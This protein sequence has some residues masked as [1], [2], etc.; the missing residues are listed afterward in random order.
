MKW[1]TIERSLP[2]RLSPDSKGRL[3]MRYGQNAR[4]ENAGVEKSGA[5]SRGGKR[6]SRQAVW[7]TEPILYIERHLSYFLKLSSD[8]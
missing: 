7:K 1:S 2:F 3:Q 5:D 4:V 6:R 8:F